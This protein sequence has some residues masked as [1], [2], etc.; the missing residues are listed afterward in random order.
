MLKLKTIP[1]DQSNISG[2]GSDADKQLRESA[3]AQEQ[4]YH[5]AG[6]EVGVLVWRIENFA[7]KLQSKDQYG[8]FYTGD[9]Y[10]VLNTYLRNN[11][12]LHNLHFWLGNEST[13]D[14][15]GSA[16]YLTVVLDDL[17]KG[18]PVQFRET[19]GNESDE[20]LALFPHFILMNGGIASGFNH[21]KPEE[22][23]PR[24]LQV[25]G[26]KATVK[27]TEVPLS[28]ASMNLGD[29]FLVDNGKQLYLWQGPFTSPFEKA[30]AAE[31]AAVLK[32]SRGNAHL[33]ILSQGDDDNDEFWKLVGGR[34]DIAPA[35]EE[36]ASKPEIKRSN[37]WRLS[38]ASGS[39]SL[40]LVQEGELH[41]SKL[42]GDDIFFLD[43]TRVLYVW[44]G[45]G[46]S[47]GEKKNALA[48]AQ[49]LIQSEG[50]PKNTNIQRII[51]DCEN[52]RFWTLFVQ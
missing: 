2:L 22:Y 38:D 36:E 13:Q 49:Q 23:K 32:G 10:I 41:R 50:L 6:T 29:T 20:F 44:I 15:V 19:Q 51:Q 48:Y 37:L 43:T 8:Y 45:N 52:E 33:V 30:K 31:L 9:S 3:A 47:I 21:V 1:I 39:L 27:A 28:R 34:G 42:D 5:G 16:A 35:K 46:A 7:P 11:K 26:R 17:L 40:N 14:E 18:L 4:A 24:M 12:K 25:V